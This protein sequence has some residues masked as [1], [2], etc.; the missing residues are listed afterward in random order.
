MQP[1]HAVDML[2]DVK[3]PMHDGVA[4]STDIYLPNTQGR[5]PTVLMRTPYSNN[6]DALIENTTRCMF[7]V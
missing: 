6:M 1:N 5:V 4:L 7:A 2:L 3:V